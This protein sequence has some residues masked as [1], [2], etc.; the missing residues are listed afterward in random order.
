MALN[1]NKRFLREEN[2]KAYAF[3]MHIKSGANEDQKTFSLL[4]NVYR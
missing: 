1:D 2:K 4:P 3:N